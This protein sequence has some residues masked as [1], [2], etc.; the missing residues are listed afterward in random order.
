MKLI[1]ELWK[2][3]EGLEGVYQISSK[4]NLRSPDRWIIDK[5]GKRK[6]LKAHPVKV[7]PQYSDGTGYIQANLRVNGKYVM[8]L[9]HRLVAKAFIPNPDNL[10]QVNY[11]DEN[12]YNNDV[13]NL[14]WLSRLDNVRY[15]T[16]IDRMADKHSIPIVQLDINGN[17]IKE[18]RS[19][20]KAASDGNFGLREA[21]REHRSIYNE[22]FWIEK[23][24]YINMTKEQLRE[25][26]SLEIN[27]SK[28]K[29][30]NA[31]KTISDKRSK[32]IVQLNLDGS[33]VKEWKSAQETYHDGFKA[34]D[35]RACVRGEQ[36]TS[37]GYKWMDLEEYKRLQKNY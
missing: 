3:I 19:I 5:N 20:R 31:I 11:I 30:E 15:G 24:K 21:F 1:S 4:G 23:E 26:I 9:V 32:S 33:F 27:K 7:R 35:I 34:G 13:N 10:E 14:E 36:K 16:G 22:Y 28:Q 25:F 6:F 12:K 29:E 17:F 18:Y 8:F 2:D 37:Q